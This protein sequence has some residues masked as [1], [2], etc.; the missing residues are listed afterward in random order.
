MTAE[1]LDI[2][3]AVETVMFG[4]RVLGWA[5]CQPGNQPV[6]VE[7]LLDGEPQAAAWTSIPRQD[8]GGDFGFALTSPRPLQPSDWLLGRTVLR[9]QVEGAAPR[10][11]PL[12][13]GVR[14]MALQGWTTQLLAL[15][16]RDFGAMMQGLSAHP[17]FAR[18][19]M[20]HPE[21]RA[22]PERARVA[23]V[24]AGLPGTPP[25]GGLAEV[26]WVLAP[27]GYQSV[28]GTALLGRGG[29]VFAVGGPNRPLDES[30]RDPAAPDVQRSATAWREVVAGRVRH[31]AERGIGFLQVLIPEKQ[32]VL[33]EYLPVPWPV[34]IALWRAL[35]QQVAAAPELAAAVVDAL[36]VLRGLAEQGEVPFMTLDS[37]LTSPAALRLFEA[38]LARMGLAPPFTVA[39]DRQEVM[40]GDLALRMFGGVELPESYLVPDAAFEAAVATTELVLRE[41]PGPMFK[42]RHIWRNPAAPLDAK[43]VCFGNSFFGDGGRP[44]KL[45]YWFARAFREFHFC[46]SP[47]FEPD[48]V[49]EHKPDWVLC[50][51][52]ERFMTQ[53]PAR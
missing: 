42:A 45:S 37:H 35:E 38:L 30:L 51:T 6:Q 28:D 25:A 18:W 50:Q 46:W 8:L 5:R 29:Q 47:D 49:A 14:D 36:P 48:Y 44:Q 43:V 31:C 17:G 11:L 21:A 4:T 26:G 2:S 12:A 19:V 40:L 53:V 41:I 33:P 34:P 1:A 9:G 52:I 23:A 16:E 32:T 13:A 22:M 10:V 7:L 15:G 3:G 20:H 27:V 24:L 39:F